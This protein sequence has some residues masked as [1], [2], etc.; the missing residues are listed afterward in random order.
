MVFNWF[1]LNYGFR[2]FGYS[3][4]SKCDPHFPSFCDYSSTINLKK[5]QKSLMEAFFQKYSQKLNENSAPGQNGQC[6]IWTGRSCTPNGE[7]GVLNCKFPDARGWRQIHVHRLAYM[8]RHQN[9]N[10]DNFDVSHLCHNTKCINANHLF[11]EP[12]GF[13]NSW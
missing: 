10:L 8:I 11:L 5:V 4:F 13:N 3:Y 2:L 12:Q 9:V 6:E 1:W 7:Y